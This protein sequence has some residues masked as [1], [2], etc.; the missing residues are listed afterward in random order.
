M[1]VAEAAYPLV[2]I[3]PSDGIQAVGV[4]FFKILIGSGTPNGDADPWMSA[5]LGSKY[6][7][8]AGVNEYIKIAEN[9]ADADWE[10]LVRYEAWM[11]MV[12]AGAGTPD[13]SD[14][15]VK[16][17]IYFQTNAAD[18][19]QSLFVKVDDAGEAADWVAV[20]LEG[21]THT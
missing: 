2:A 9:D 16:G 14:S 1:A 4:D 5:A 10:K 19:A 7:D 21:H 20:S 15:L 3:L 8:I 11:D 12:T 17:S 13:G 6:I 18:D